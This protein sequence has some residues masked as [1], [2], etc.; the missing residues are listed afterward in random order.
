MIII[1]VTVVCVSDPNPQSQNICCRSSHYFS[2]IFMWMRLFCK[3][4]FLLSFLFL[5][6][7]PVLLVKGLFCT[8]TPSR[9]L[10]QTHSSSSSPPS[11]L[12]CM[13]SPSTS[14]SLV[15][16]RFLFSFPLSFPPSHLS[17]QLLLLLL[18]FHDVLP[19][20]LLLFLCQHN[21]KQNGDNHAFRTYL[22]ADCISYTFGGGIVFASLQFNLSQVI[23]SANHS[24]RTEVFAPRGTASE[25]CI[26]SS[27]DIFQC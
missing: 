19:R 11:F 15:A 22:S 24:G 1:W 10:S 25:Y 14:A 13:T 16:F 12:F 18:A 3:C 7:L 8:I 5:A 23:L 21:I 4:F 9:S 20:T 27:L 26:Y 2:T 6:L 17:K